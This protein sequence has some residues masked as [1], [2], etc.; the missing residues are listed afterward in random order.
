MAA[1]PDPDGAVSGH[2]PIVPPMTDIRADLVD[3][4]PCRGTGTALEVLTL[5]R[6]S[7]GR[8][9]GSWESVHGHI[10]AG[11]T[12]AAAALRELR[13]ETGYQAIAL[14]NLS[15]VDLFYQSGPDRISL[16]PAFAAVIAQDDDAV[17]SAE[18]D[19]A[20]WVP[21]AAAMR[22]F[23]WPRSVRAVG[24]LVALIGSGSAG[25]LEDVLRVR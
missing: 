14:Y 4:Y 2:S 6:A 1:S 15:R 19:A 8:C 16:V 23:S 12:P 13:E 22:R 7:G 10:E 20:M 21:A 9:P 5:R 18:H 25:P 3:V 24:D 17:L 11:E